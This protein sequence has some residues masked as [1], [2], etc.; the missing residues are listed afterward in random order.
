MSWLF[1]RKKTKDS[2]SD[3]GEETASNIDDYI[4]VEKQV[5]APSPVG[6]AGADPTKNFGLYPYL[7]QNSSTNVP[8]IP[9]NVSSLDILCD[10]PNYLPC[11]KFQLNKMLENDVEMDR[12][13]ADE[14]LSFI[15]RIKSENYD[16]DFSLENSV[17]NEMAT[18]SG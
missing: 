13:H 18:S 16:Y 5:N 4:L 6:G 11:I 2:P 12:I 15:L 9:S 8:Q 3:S 7:P 1:G 10:A 17:I 14:I